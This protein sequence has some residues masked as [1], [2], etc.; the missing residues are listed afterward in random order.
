[1]GHNVPHNQGKSCELHSRPKSIYSGRGTS[2]IQ[3]TPPIT[4]EYHSVLHSDPTSLLSFIMKF[5]SIYALALACLA[6]DAMA[7][8]RF[9]GISLRSSSPVHQLPVTG[10]D[11]KIWLGG[12]TKSFCPDVVEPNCPPGKIT[13]F[14]SIDKSLY[15]NAEVAGGQEGESQPTSTYKSC[16]LITDCSS[17]SKSTVPILTISQCISLIT[18]ASRTPLPTQ[19]LS[20]RGPKLNP[21]AMSRVRT[22][23]QEY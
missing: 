17:I 13:G 3:P 4:F 19:V 7:A 5:S 23:R 14:V 8:K 2:N 18:V 10:H 6:G 15:M 1:M 12:K 22:I 20:Q 21:S 11:N 9:E 16:L